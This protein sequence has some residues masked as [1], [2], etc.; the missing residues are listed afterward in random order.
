[1]KKIYTLLYFL[2]IAGILNGFSQQDYAVV[3]FREAMKQMEMRNLNIADSLF[4]ISITLRPSA[5]AYYNRAQ[6]KYQKQDMISYCSD[7]FNASK[8]GD[9]QADYLYKKKCMHCDSFVRAMNTPQR[10]DQLPEFSHL[11]Q[12]I[13]EYIAEHLVYPA[14]A[15]Y[16]NISGTVYFTFVIDNTGKPIECRIIKG[17]G[18][19]CDEEVCRLIQNMPLWTPASYLHTDGTLIPVEYKM[20]MQVV[21]K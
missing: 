17:I 19:G 16:N 3:N 7:M 5:E 15:K 21:F 18:Y 6:I 4:T 8:L 14:N 12:N 2:A 11:G 9:P 20:N 1:M 10:I 13:D